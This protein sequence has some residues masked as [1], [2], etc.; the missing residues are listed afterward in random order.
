M[1]DSDDRIPVRELARG[2]RKRTW[3]TARLMSKIGVKMAKANLGMG[4]V[5]A[6]VDEDEAV[7]AATALV[8]Q[9][10]GLKGLAMKIGQMISYLDASL[11]P[12]AQRIL[13]RLQ[14]DSKPMAPDM[15]RDLVCAE[16]GAAPEQVFDEFEPMPFA[17]ASI[18]QVHRA[19]VGDRAVAVKVQYPGIDEL[20]RSDLKA[21][22]RL[23][24]IAMAVG[25]VDGKAMTKELTDRLM[26]ECDYELEAT[27][28]ERFRALFADMPGVAIPKVLREYST[29]RVLTSELCDGMGFY[30]FCDRGSQQAKNRAAQRI[31]AGCFTAIYRYCAYNADPHPGNYLFD[32]H[33]NVTLL[34]FGCVKT[35]EPTMIRTWKQVAR[36]IMDNDEAALRDGLIAAGFIRKQRKFDWAHQ[37]EAM[38]Y[39]Y[40]PMIATEPFRFTADYVSNVHDVLAFKNKNK[41]KLT[42]PADWLFVNRLQFGMFSILA[43]LN[44]TATWRDTFRPLVYDE[45]EPVPF[46]GDAFGGDAFRILRVCRYASA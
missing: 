44:A 36:A 5:A 34:D 24:R 40:R 45:N 7:A 37:L 38:R 11:P 9:L 31:Y 15:I 13:A 1:G 3:A 46:G 2:F 32:E 6:K 23:G 42:M 35:F 27:N 29:R 41:F 4:E 8:E 25:P 21:I 28:Q 17:A 26:E 14:F 20:M 43:H 39:L 10:D 19:R 22:S 12:K 18:G 33:G 16:L 30:E